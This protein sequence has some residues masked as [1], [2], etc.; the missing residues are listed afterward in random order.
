[1]IHTENAPEYLDKI[2]DAL[3]SYMEQE[4]ILLYGVRNSIVN[5]LTWAYSNQPN[6]MHNNVLWESIGK[7]LKQYDAKFVEK[8]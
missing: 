7:I 4:R 6:P 3:P 1:M 5:H 2:I 8:K